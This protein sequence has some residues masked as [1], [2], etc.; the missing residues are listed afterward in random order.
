MSTGKH[1][2]TSKKPPPNPPE[3]ISQASPKHPKISANYQ[4]NQQK[5][6][7]GL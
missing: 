6:S 7:G 2:N 3:H 4:A 1:A 5:H